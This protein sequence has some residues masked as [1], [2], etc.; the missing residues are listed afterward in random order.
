MDKILILLA[1]QE[2]FWSTNHFV[3]LEQII[4]YTSAND[5]LNFLLANFTNK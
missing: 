4:I 2:L 3:G 1:T 5:K